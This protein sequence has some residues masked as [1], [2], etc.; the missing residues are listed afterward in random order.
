MNNTV[1]NDF[2]GFPKVKWP[3]YV[4][5]V[6]KCTS[7]QCQIFSGFNTPKMTKIG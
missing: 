7:Y 4:G 5:K 1:E 3:Q 6:G 2:L